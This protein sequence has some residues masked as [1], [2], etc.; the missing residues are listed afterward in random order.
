[1]PVPLPPPLPPHATAANVASNNKAS[2]TYPRHR[3]CNRAKDEIPKIAKIDTTIRVRGA[4]AGNGIYVGPGR[5]LGLDLGPTVEDAVVLS[6]TVGDIVPLAVRVTE[7]PPGKLHV[8][9]SVTAVGATE[10]LSVT[11]PAKE[12]RLV[13]V[14]PALP[15]PPGALI[16]TAFAE[17][18][19]ADEIENVAVAVTVIVMEDDRAEDV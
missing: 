13:T 4:C 8:G 3:C 16:G 15:V 1:M 6:M 9:S 17:E 5:D 14:S 12:F 7:L 10:Q 18:L 2:H 19:L 11:V